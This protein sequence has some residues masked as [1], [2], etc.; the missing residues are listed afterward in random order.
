MIILDKTDRDMLN[1]MF[2]DIRKQNVDISRHMKVS[3]Y[4]SDVLVFS[5]W[6][7]NS[8]TYMRPLKKNERLDNP[9]MLDYNAVRI[10][11]AKPKDSV[12]VN[13]GV[14]EYTVILNGISIESF[15]LDIEDFPEMLNT[16]GEVSVGPIEVTAEKL[17]TLLPGMSRDAS[18]TILN[19]YCFKEDSMFCT[20][21]RVLHATKVDVDAEANKEG[22][23]L[24]QTDSN[25]L[26]IPANIKRLGGDTKMTVS[27]QAEGGQV[28]SHPA[29]QIVFSV[30]HNSGA[31]TFM[32]I[33]KDIHGVPPNFKQV[34]PDESQ[35]VNL[36]FTPKE[37][38][39]L[40]TLP[41]EYENLRFNS[42]ITSNSAGIPIS[43]PLETST[44][45]KTACSRTRLLSICQAGVLEFKQADGDSPLHAD[46]NGYKFVLMPMRLE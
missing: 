34:V 17:L 25:F 2:N 37:V 19:G 44:K 1:M 32:F 21:G 30:R 45:F 10:R 8:L 24:I 6:N 18:R 39:Q 40:S 22:F 16:T 4:G 46:H 5:A 28:S 7:G 13:P 29:K 12:V 23:V 20:D 31:W 33:H 27:V 14:K 15:G 35:G 9:F 42:C 26:R 36:K 38:E 11:K 43:V 41:K 3:T